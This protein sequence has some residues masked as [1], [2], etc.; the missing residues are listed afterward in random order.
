MKRQN[1][2]LEALFDAFR[3]EDIEPIDPEGEAEAIKRFQQGHVHQT[4]EGEKRPRFMYVDPDRKAV[5]REKSPPVAEGE[6]PASSDKRSS[7][8]RKHDANEAS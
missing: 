6:K 4:V 3:E 7:H 8:K 1:D 5:E 2:P